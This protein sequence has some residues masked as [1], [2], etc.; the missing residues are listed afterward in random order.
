MFLFKESILKTTTILTFAV[1]NLS[2]SVGAQSITGV[3]SLP[4]TY[5]IPFNVNEWDGHTNLNNMA[6]VNTTT[7][8][9]YVPVMYNGIGKVVEINGTNNSYESIDLGWQPYGIAVD[10]QRNNLYVPS[11]GPDWQLSFLNINTK[12]W[13]HFNLPPLDDARAFAGEIAVNPN[14]N[15]IYFPNYAHGYVFVMDGNNHTWQII[16]TNENPPAVSIKNSYSIAVNTSTNR[17][18][19]TSEASAFQIVVIDANNNNAVTRVSLPEGVRLNGAIAVNPITNRIYAI[20]YAVNNITGGFHFSILVMNGADN[21]FTTIPFPSA[22]YNLLDDNDDNRNAYRMFS[23][24]VVNP[25]TNRVYTTSVGQN[26]FT[27]ESFLI[28]SSLKFMTLDGNT[29]AVTVKSIDN[30][31]IKLHLEHGLTMNPATNLIYAPNSHDNNGGD[32]SERVL[33]IDPGSSGTISA[34]SPVVQADS[35]TLSFSNV[36]SPGTVSVI[37]ISDAAMAG[38]VPGGFAVSDLLAFEIHPDA[39]LQFTGPVISCFQVPTVNDENTFNSLAVLHRELNI[40]TN[41]YQ[42][43]DRTSSKS[44]LTR[45]ICAST[46]SFSPFFLARMGNK[47]KSLFDRTKAYKSGSTVPVKIQLLNSS[48]ANISSPST[49]L[50]A[51]SLRLIGGNTTSTVADSGNSNPDANFRYD[52]SLHGYIFN[53]STRDLSAGR[54]VLSFYSGTDRS[55]FYTVEFEVK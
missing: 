48:D 47:I 19:V 17:V 42:L 51:R 36:T 50:T 26:S 12:A 22:S 11:T 40:S 28:N 31:G 2:V 44:F 20:S 14:N 32:Q 39:A 15:R 21:S 38:D 8:K 45:T 24:I 34:A 5:E 25:L 10:S 33:V 16:N 9:I 18:Y 4:D 29:N 52:S 53:L 7:N 55:F 43:V 54:Y 30:A 13:Q 46:T 27:P 23:S 6:I 1:A 35:T 37:P 41:Q 49:P 3:V